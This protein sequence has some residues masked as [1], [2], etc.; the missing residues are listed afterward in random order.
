[1]SAR[2]FVPAAALLALLTS[3]PAR[4]QDVSDLDALLNE[5]VSS[6][7]SKSAQTSTDV[8]ALSINLTAEDLRRYGIRTLAEAYDFLGLGI[9]SEDPLGE[10]E[11][12][13]R[14]VLL[15][16]DA[17]K[18]ILLLLDGHVTNDQRNGASYHSESAGI[19]VELID[20]V[21]IMLGPGSVLYGSNAMLGVINVVTKRAKDFAGIHL[22][23]EVGAS[24]PQNQA[25]SLVS[26]ALDSQYF[27]DLGKSYRLSA[28]LG[29]SFQLFGEPAEL[30]AALE[31]FAVVGPTL[32]WAT[33]NTGNFNYGPRAPVG[34]WGGQTSQ[35]H[36][37]QTPS[38]Y[39]RL[40]R[41]DLQLTLH[42]LANHAAAPYSRMQESPRDFDD[43]RSF[44]D[45]S[46]G[47]IDLSWNN[48]VSSV[49]SLSARV[50][51]DAS[52]QYSQ[53]RSSGFFGCLATQLNGCIHTAEGH[54]EWAGTELQATI[55]WL[56]DRSM[57]SMVGLEG[58]I[59]HAAFESGIRDFASEGTV[60]AFGQY[61]ATDVMG[62]IYG[63]QVYRP[64]G[65]LTLNVGARLDLDH[66]FGQRLSPRAAAVADAWHGATTKLIYSE[67]FRAPTPEEL[68]LT[69]RYLVLASPDLRPETER[70]VEALLQQRLGSQRMVIGVFRTWWDNMVSREHLSQTE[71]S[72]GQR[73]GLLDSS[74]V[75]VFQ[76]RNVARVDD[77]GFQ[78]SYEG[79]AWASRLNYGVNV[80]AAYSRVRGPQGT[81]LMTV[82]PSVYGNARVSYDAGGGLPVVGIAS[83][84]SGRRLADIGQ[85]P[86]VVGLLYA[87][88]MLDMRLT[89]SGPIPGV[90]SLQ[91][92]LV[93]DYAFTTTNPYAVNAGGSNENLTELI[94]FT[95]STLLLGVGY[96]FK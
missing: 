81:S 25:H 63:Q 71:L 75:S 32:G 85:D 17:G 2:A 45:R 26:P 91:Y 44:G 59:R 22:V 94:P 96:D 66:Q 83:Q 92:R 79:S 95:R 13:S 29:E 30:T 40:Q 89:L 70:S 21:E 47:G 67:A 34:A 61:G 19:P 52:R 42:A 4:A 72:A 55:D 11:V 54:A 23:G 58:R 6:T 3:G 69:N 15:S 93:A 84:M 24:L 56:S 43:S 76:F 46:A 50:Y 27:R 38:G 51:G 48:A 35:S 18:H 39:V 7:A 49:M 60:A 53:V 10:P 57:S 1:M 5:P 14:G 33:V 86:G 62:A 36:Y 37:Q 74:T 87:A 77:Y 82:T 68:H 88:P 9:V 16:N 12:G 20:H 73:A 31:Y 80:T 65:W 78:A 41:G 64:T 8:P 90:S 28:G